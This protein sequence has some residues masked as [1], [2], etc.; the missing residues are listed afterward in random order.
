MQVPES[1]SN[2][3][4]RDALLQLGQEVKELRQEVKQLSQAIKRPQNS[5][6]TNSTASDRMIQ[7]AI[8]VIIAA[9][10]VSVVSNVTAVILKSL[11]AHSF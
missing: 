1:P 10:I 2:K 6:R 3:D 4:I 7:G 11:T 9:A 8:W 5:V